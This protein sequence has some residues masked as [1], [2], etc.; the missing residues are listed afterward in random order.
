MKKY[1]M[2]AKRSRFSSVLF[3][4]P[5]LDAEYTTFDD[6]QVEIFKFYSK[7]INYLKK[8]LACKFGGSNPYN[9]IKRTIS[10]LIK[11]EV[12]IKCTWLGR[13]MKICLEKSPIAKL[14]IRE[15]G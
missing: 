8:I 9:F 5:A 14:I 4:K 3:G 7:C 6:S 13:K 11:D 12:L 2:R 10:C 15:Y 1:Y